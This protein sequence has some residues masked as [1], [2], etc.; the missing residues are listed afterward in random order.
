MRQSRRI[1]LKTLGAGAVF[2]SLPEISCIFNLFPSRRASDDDL[3]TTLCGLFGGSAASGGPFVARAES[4]VTET[5]PQ[6]LLSSPSALINIMEMLGVEKT[7]SDRVGYG[8]A[9]QCRPHF[10]SQ[11]EEWRR[12]LGGDAIFT[13]VRRSPSEKDVAVMVGG[14]V[15]P[16]SNTL[17]R[18]EGAV[19][20]QHN[21]AVLLAGCDSGVLLAASTAARNHIELSAKNLAR[22]YALVE[23]AKPVE[24]DA[25]QSA[26]RY[27]T[28]VH[29][30]VYIPRARRNNRMGSRAV[31]VVAV[32]YKSAPENIYFAD[33]YV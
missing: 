20:Y 27:E 16:S 15:S 4:I 10:H 26:R 33:L 9:S 21:P 7:F 31:G 12:R 18:A 25:R 8:E 13:D 14:K 30:V 3:A 1:F 17:E 24:M 23:P 19:Q 5:S 2:V 29:S 6:Q 11:E 32:N 22:S 28:P